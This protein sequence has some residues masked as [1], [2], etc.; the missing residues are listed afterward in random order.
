MQMQYRFAVHSGTLSK[1]DTLRIVPP[2]CGLRSLTPKDNK[3]QV[4]PIQHFPHM[5]SHNSARI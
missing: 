3:I 5:I 4:T 2:N 1:Y